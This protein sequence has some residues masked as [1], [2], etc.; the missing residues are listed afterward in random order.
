MIASLVVAGLFVAWALSL[1]WDMGRLRGLRECRRT[2]GPRL[3][4][5]LADGLAQIQAALDEPYRE[6]APGGPSQDLDICRDLWPD[7]SK[8]LPKEWS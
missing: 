7:A 2:H 4:P 5:A 8:H 3:D 1:A 6:T